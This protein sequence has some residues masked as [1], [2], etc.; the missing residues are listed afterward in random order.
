MYGANH[1]IKFKA[2]P[3]IYISRYRKFISYHDTKFFY[4][5]YQIR[6][7]DTIQAVII[8]LNDL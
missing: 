1:T 3:E 4:S 7:M 6:T 5:Y 2:K 8:I